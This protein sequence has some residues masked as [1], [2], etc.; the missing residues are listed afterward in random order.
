M[1]KKKKGKYFI[2]PLHIYPFDVLVSVGQTDKEF[3]KLLSKYGVLNDFKYQMD[4]TTRVGKFVM[5][6]DSRVVLRFKYYPTTPKIIATVSHESQHAVFAMFDVIGIKFSQESEE[7]Y[8]Y[9]TGYLVEEI[10]KKSIC[11]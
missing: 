5:F 4:N 1:A 3:E 11:K 6:G 10:L 7:S 8:T 2:V 9:T